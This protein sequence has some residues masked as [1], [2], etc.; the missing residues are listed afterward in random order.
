MELKTAV[1]SLDHLIAAKDP[2]FDMSLVQ[3]V[4]QVSKGVIGCQ[5]RSLQHCSTL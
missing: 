4:S 1:D 5:S 2:S 3:Q